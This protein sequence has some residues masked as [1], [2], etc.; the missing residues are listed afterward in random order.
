M[1]E[2]LPYDLSRL[3]DDDYN[4]F[5]TSGGMN[6]FT[7][8]FSGGPTL[9]QVSEKTGRSYEDILNEYDSLNNGGGFNPDQ[10]RVLA[11]A[12]GFGPRANTGGSVFDGIGSGIKDFAGQ[13]GTGAV[14]VGTGGA[15]VP[16]SGE[17]WL[18]G[19]VGDQIVETATL[20]AYNPGDDKGFLEGG[21]IG[22]SVLSGV[23]GGGVDL[24]SEQDGNG[25][26]VDGAED[27][28]GA[29]A[30]LMGDVVGGMT[31]GDSQSEAF[32]KYW[33]YKSEQLEGASDAFNSGDPLNPDF[34]QD[35]LDY[36]QG[37]RNRVQDGNQNLN[38]ASTELSGLFGQSDPTSYGNVTSRVGNNPLTDFYN[39]PNTKGLLAG[40]KAFDQLGRTANGEYLN[41]NPYL[42][43]MFDRASSKVSDAF[44]SA[45][46][47]KNSNFSMA[48]RYGS[49]AHQAA[50]ARQKEAL[51]DTL[52][53]LA[54]DIYGGNY[55]QERDRMVS[56]L[57]P[58]GSFS[59]SAVNRQ[60]SGANQLGNQFN[61]DTST[62]FGV[63]QA[64]SNQYN[65][66][67]NNSLNTINPAFQFAG[68]DFNELGQL[69]LVGGQVD[70]LN[71]IQAQ[72]PW[73]KVNNYGAAI[74]GVPTGGGGQGG[75]SPWGSL[76]GAGLGALMAP[77][78]S[79][80]SGATLGA[81]LGGLFN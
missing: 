42:D 49:G 51:G 60:M 21:N 75:G 16:G 30:D 36:Q 15:V 58:L 55:Q 46:D 74:G 5:K 52:G 43:Q 13:L 63:N 10:A 24:R 3:G 34:S 37:V 31:Q 71:T 19:K 47:A 29:T 61:Q 57:N 17:G 70:S 73:Q 35:T 12:S 33:P 39:D 41:N 22:A 40:N 14:A 4:P 68:N 67:F 25:W 65:Q 27:L 23:T 64:G 48:G 81:G 2:I 11:E 72:E 18:E 59:D 6:P 1:A 54:T 7:P 45:V 28:G 79:G 56:A 78:G 77:S 53:G 38:S 44:S 50:Q 66:N 62:L 8:M 76:L 26:L 20:G 80:I 32:N 9:Q 69:G